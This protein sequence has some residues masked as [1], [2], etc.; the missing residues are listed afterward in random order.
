MKRQSSRNAKTSSVTGEVD[1][2]IRA[3]PKDARAN[4]LQ[5]RRLI[6]ST[7]PGA[8]ETI[9]YRM[10][11]YTYYGA[12]VWFAAFKNHLSIYLRPPVIQEHK[13]ELKGYQTTKSAVHLPMN[14][15]LPIALIRKLIKARISKN[16]TAMNVMNA[17]KSGN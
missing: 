6:K 5:L 10:P 4:L 13:L 8:K 9:S 14:K 16:K 3:A 7:A 12:L 17:K 11:C 2:Y 15:P 1:A